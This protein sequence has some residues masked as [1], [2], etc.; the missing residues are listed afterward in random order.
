MLTQAGEAMLEI[1][2]A[3]AAAGRSNSAAKDTKVRV[4]DINLVSSPWR[5]SGWYQPGWSPYG[6]IEGSRVMDGLLSSITFAAGSDC[7]GLPR[8]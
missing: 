2:W 4:S 1:L 5:R 3:D 8:E 6:S 7:T